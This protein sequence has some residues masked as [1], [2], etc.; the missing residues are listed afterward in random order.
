VRDGD[1]EDFL[2]P[3]AHHLR[4]F[5]ETMRVVARECSAVD[6]RGRDDGQQPWPLEQLAFVESEDG[7]V[8]G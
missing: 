7:D 8:M 1:G 6:R 2:S 5:F 3:H 4:H